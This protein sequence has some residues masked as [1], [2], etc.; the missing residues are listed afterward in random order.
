M[1]KHYRIT[2]KGRV[3]GVWF[4]K[5]TREAA[6]SRNLSGLVRNERNGTVY[7]ESEG[8]EKDLESFIQWLHKGSPMSKV[9]EVFWEEGGCKD[10]SGFEIIR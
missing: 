1:F 4:R 2:V 10:F 6:I 8:N 7:I 5:Y 3:Q 9:E